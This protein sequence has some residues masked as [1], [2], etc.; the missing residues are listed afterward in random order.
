MVRTWRS[1]LR[2]MAAGLH[3]SPPENALVRHSQNPPGIR[4]WINEQDKNPRT[5]IWTK[6]ADEILATLAACCQRSNDA[7]K[8]A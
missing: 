1:R 3:L 4:A 8:P 5:F 2:S 6:T 7:V